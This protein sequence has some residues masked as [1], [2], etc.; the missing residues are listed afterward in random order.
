MGK[1][2]KCTLCDKYTSERSSNVIRH[3][4]EVHKASD[5]DIKQFK[6][7]LNSSI[8]VTKHGQ[9]AWKCDSCGLVVPTKKG[10]ESHVTRKHPKKPVNPADI[11]LL[12]D[13][14]SSTK[15]PPPKRIQL[16]KLINQS[17]VTEKDTI[18]S[19]TVTEVN[20]RIACPFPDCTEQFRTRE[21]L[22]QHYAT[23]HATESELEHASFDTE[24]EFQAW[25][26]LIGENTCSGWKVRNSYVSG[27]VI[28]K[29]HVCRHEGVYKS[30]ASVL[31]VGASKKQTGS[32]YCPAFLKVQ[33]NSTSGKITVDGYFEHCG[34]SLEH[35]L[36]AMSEADVEYILR[37]MREGFT[38]SQ[39]I[40]KCDKLPLNSRLAYLVPDDLRYIRNKNDLSEGRF[41]KDDFESLRLRVERATE[42]DG[43]LLYEPPNKDGL[44]MR[45]VIMTPAQR[46]LCAKYSHR[47]ICID[48]THN[49]TKYPLKLTT[50]LVLNGQDRGIPIEK[51]K[52]WAT[53]HRKGAPFQTS[54][55]SE[56]WHSAL[57]KDILHHNTNIR[58][59]QLV[60]MLYNGFN[61]VIRRIVKQTGR[62]LKKASSRRTETMKKCKQAAQDIENYS[63]FRLN[64]KATEHESVDFDMN[65]DDEAFQNLLMPPMRQQFVVPEV[66][67]EPAD[68]C[69]ILYDQF[70]VEVDRL[71]ETMRR[72]CK[73]GQS[74]SEMRAILDF[75]KNANDTVSDKLVNVPTRRDASKGPKSARET[76]QHHKLLRRTKRRPDQPR[77]SK[78]VLEMSKDPSICNV[79]KLSDP[80]LPEDM[81]EEELDSR[82]TEWRRCSNCKNPV[83]FVCSKGCCPSCGGDFQPYLPSD[84][85]SEL[86]S[87]SD[88][89][90]A[91]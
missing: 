38:N 39:I 75:I 62:Q 48:D 25:L 76:M 77:R 81:D 6:V 3:L 30:K 72:L 91:T 84:S 50:M 23:V 61:W 63:I 4:R 19:P 59:D 83:H 12:A 69:K 53:C 58:I 41:H 34:H 8:A 37:L 70:S 29:Y 78:I 52:L 85:G 87:S 45:L 80:L 47:G 7:L 57:K 46:E 86:A 65:F 15:S 5:E 31:D 22:A 88:D 56:N 74:Q 66:S 43:F 13:E 35:G 18:S 2:I 71:C 11:S 44:G 20:G 1:I 9:G 16:D 10:L 21:G 28:Q 32:S 17:I 26:Q 68:E 67:V 42:E 24:T 51:V 89:E 49:P 79:C 90:S 54:M 64:N 14:S 60:Q 27:D 82:V 40:D 73:T 33:I 55:Y 36:R